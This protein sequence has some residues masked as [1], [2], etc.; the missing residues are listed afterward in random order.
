MQN[1]MKAIKRKISSVSALAVLLLI[2]CSC[3]SQTTNDNIE[4]TW[5]GTSVCQVKNSPCHDE[6]VV[7]HISK[8]SKTDMY[9]VQMNKIVNN[10][11]E[12]MGRLDFSY[13]KSSQTLTCIMKNQ[14]QREGTWKFIIKDRQITGTLILEGNIL[15]RKIEVSKK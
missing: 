2:S 7:C 4:G 13:D 6:S 11:E 1:K 15:Y 9:T 5:K 14:Q 10:A 8:S 3:S 12:E